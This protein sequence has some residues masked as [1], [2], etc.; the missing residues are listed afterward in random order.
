MKTVELEGKFYNWR[1]MSNSKW[2]P[3]EN[4]R[5]ALLTD[6]LS[7]DGMSELNN[8][9]STDESDHQTLRP[10]NIFF[11]NKMIKFTVCV[12]YGIIPC[13]F[14]DH[15]TKH[16]S[17]LLP[18]CYVLLLW[19]SVFGYIYCTA[20]FWIRT[21]D[22]INIRNIT[23]NNNTEVSK[24]EELPEIPIETL[25]LLLGLALSGAVTVTMAVFYFYTK[26]NDFSGIKNDD[27]NMLPRLD[28]YTSDD[29]EEI[30][31]ISDLPKKEWLIAN[32]LC[33]FG[34][35][36]VIF[37]LATDFGTDTL[38]DF[39]GIRAFL[40]TTT[41]SNRAIYIVAVTML[42]WGFGGTVSAC[43]IFH[44]MSRNL[45]M[46][47]KYT[48]RCILETALTRDEFFRLHER[49]IMYTERMIDRFKFWFAIH[50]SMFILL[51]AAM[52]FEWI[53]FMRNSKYAH[54][55]ILSQVAGT[56][57]ICY[58]FAFPLISASRVTVAFKELYVATFRR[59]QFKDIPELLLLQNQFGFTIF[60]LRITP[61]IA[62][63]V[64]FSSFLGILKFLSGEM[65]M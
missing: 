65:N 47:I 56:V 41:P 27:F 2:N 49:L 6:V 58:K 25:L 35:L 64:F 55:Y 39:H 50:N 34:I 17:L 59:N 26:N 22:I 33:I 8:E 60:G 16:R 14:A 32:I 12:F 24:R 62:I 3:E 48:E 19:Y 42:F 30:E 1:T 4:L 13:L 5:Q 7:M 53:T 43:C 51:V 63:L 20:K 36:N 15:K 61:S 23:S 46:F 38:F 29:A 45:V 31:H 10:K 54:N 11:T 28:L 44:I 52:I 40:K 9:R 18:L 37:V 57:L 21:K